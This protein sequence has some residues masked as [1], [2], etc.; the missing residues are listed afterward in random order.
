M[1]SIVHTIVHNAHLIVLTHKGL[2]VHNSS[3]VHLI[4]AH[5]H[6]LDAEGESEK[7]VLPGL[8]VATFVGTGSRVDNEHGNIRLRCAGDHIL[9][10]IAVA[11]SI[12]NGIG[13]VLCL[14]LASGYVDG[15][16]TNA[17]SL[18]GVEYPCVFAGK[19]LC[20]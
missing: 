13:Y 19:I 7:R 9:D 15:D 11:W 1:W 6:L 2:I 5:D 18:Q 16:A 20:R 10:V 3:V 12:D 8:T 4:D 14:H 17:L